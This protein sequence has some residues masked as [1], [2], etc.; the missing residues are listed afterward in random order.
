MA[1]L[2]TILG[3][4]EAVARLAP[5]EMVDRCLVEAGHGPERAADQVELVLDD[6]V[7]RIQRPSVMQAPP[8]A[9]FGWPIEPR[10]VLP[11]YVAE[12]DAGPFN[13]GKTSELSTV[14]IR[15]AGSL[16]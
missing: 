14:A 1:V 4:D 6:Q 5:R 15:K 3:A 10:L 13:P 2:A 8:K 9:G 12:E 16:R 7:G 11:I